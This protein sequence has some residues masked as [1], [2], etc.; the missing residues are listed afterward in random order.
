MKNVINKT[1]KNDRNTIIAEILK[2]LSKRLFHLSISTM[3]TTDM[4]S[5]YAQ[6]ASGKAAIK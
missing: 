5:K 2:M 6:R 3:S 4:H 1:I